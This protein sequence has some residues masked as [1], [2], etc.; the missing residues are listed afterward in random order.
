M[1]APRSRPDARA[2]VRPEVVA[3]K[4]KQRPCR[5]R[6]PESP[7]AVER[8]P[9]RRQ[10]AGRQPAGR[11]RCGRRLL[12][13][14]GDRLIGADVMASPRG[15]ADPR[16]RHAHG[17]PQVDQLALHAPVA[18]FGLQDRRRQRGVTA[19]RVS[20]RGPPRQR[21]AT[22]RRVVRARSDRKTSALRQDAA[23]ALRARRPVRVQEPRRRRHIRLG[24]PREC[25]EFGAESVGRLTSVSER[26]PC[27]AGL[28]PGRDSS[29]FKS[30]LPI[31]RWRGG[32]GTGGR[33]R[34]W[35]RGLVLRHD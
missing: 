1:A 14:I 25:V 5:T 32:P 33:R 23:S 16:I 34:P 21:R 4:A 15:V 13:R 24:V 9:E 17:P 28:R 30:R 12:D 29:R 26:T 8:R 27:G 11:N 7:H 18:G 6:R 22:A 20:V 19:R 2:F 31:A 35:R 10:G 3:V